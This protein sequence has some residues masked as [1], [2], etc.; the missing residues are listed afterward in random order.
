MTPFHQQTILSL[1]CIK[2]SVNGTQI[3]YEIAIQI[4]LPTENLNT[5]LLLG[6]TGL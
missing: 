1:L 2:S 5:Y 4:Q 3:W 6:T